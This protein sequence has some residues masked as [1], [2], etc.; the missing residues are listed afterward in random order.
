S[1][2]ACRYRQDH[3]G[4]V[5]ASVS[6]MAWAWLGEAWSGTARQARSGENNEASPTETCHVRNPRAE[7]RKDACRPTRSLRGARAALSATS[8]LRTAHVGVRADRA[9]TCG[10]GR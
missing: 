4:Y 9:G 5:V 1:R 7:R 2:W 6:Y 10:A 8:N 3:H